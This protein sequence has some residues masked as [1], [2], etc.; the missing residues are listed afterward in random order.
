MHVIAITTKFIENYIVS[1]SKNK[2]VEWHANEISLE[3]AI[4]YLFLCEK[5]DLSYKTRIYDDVNVFLNVSSIL[6]QIEDAR[7]TQLCIE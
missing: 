3:N 7:D 4:R 1:F 6:E 5:Q 2:C